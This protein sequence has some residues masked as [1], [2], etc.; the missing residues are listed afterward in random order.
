MEKI[1]EL[2]KI[3]ITDKDVQDRVDSLARAAGDRAKTLREIY[4]RSEARDDLRAQIVFDRTVGFL[5]ER[6]QIKEVDP[7][8]SV[9]PLVSKVDEQAEKS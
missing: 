1:A 6:A 9:D 4:A 8:I 7:P 3:E 5:L 2:E